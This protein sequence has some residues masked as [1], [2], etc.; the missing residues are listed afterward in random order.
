MLSQLCKPAGFPPGSSEGANAWLL[1]PPTE[2]NFGEAVAGDINTSCG[3]V[4]REAVPVNM[5]LFTVSIRK[6]NTAPLPPA[7]Q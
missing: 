4:W 5:C 1:H 3:G 2:V 6:A 7:Q